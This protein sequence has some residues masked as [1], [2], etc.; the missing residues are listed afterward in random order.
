[1]KP[2][3]L[4]IAVF[5]AL[6][7]TII[8]VGVVSAAPAESSYNAVRNTSVQVTDDPEPVPTGTVGLTGTLQFT[9]PVALVISLFFNLPYTEVMEL[10]DEGIGFGVIARAYLTAL[11]SDGALTPQE[12]L[13]MH[14]SGTGWG[15]IKKSYGAHPGGNGLGATM[16]GRAITATTSI[17]PTVPGI[18]NKRQD[19]SNSG[20][21]CPGNSCNAPGQNKPNKNRGPKK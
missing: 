15:Q 18:M 1:M 14:L 4:A 8:L 21:A 12:V 6:A 3:R 10:H 5:I 11:A 20:T 17:S 13:D 19:N 2:A 9:H 7:L 16:S